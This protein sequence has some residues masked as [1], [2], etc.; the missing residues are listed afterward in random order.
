M[1]DLDVSCWSSP[2]ILRSSFVRTTSTEDSRLC[3]HIR[4]ANC[5]NCSNICNWMFHATPSCHNTLWNLVLF[6]LWVDPPGPTLH[7]IEGT[8]AVVSTKHV[9]TKK[10]CAVFFGQWLRKLVDVQK[11]GWLSHGAGPC[12]H[13]RTTRLWG[14]TDPLVW[15]LPDCSAEWQLCLY[16]RRIHQT[17]QKQR[18]AYTESFSAWGESGDPSENVGPTRGKCYGGRYRVYQLSS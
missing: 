1:L 14:M 10:S 17:S 15:R 6:F 18:R 13:G 9:D 12:R 11:E 7:F 5:Y 3:P 2:T 16:L 4:H 8:G